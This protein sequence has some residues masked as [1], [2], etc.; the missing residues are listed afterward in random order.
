MQ[1]PFFTF[2]FFALMSCS[3]KSQATVGLIQQNSAEDGYELFAP[4]KADTTYLIDKCG[5]RIHQWASPNFPGMSVYLLPD[6]SLL[7]SANVPNPVF[8]GNGA[9]GGAI[10]KYDWNNNL[11]W[12]YTISTDTQ[13]QNH[14]IYPMPNGNILLVIWEAIDSSVAVAAGKN[15]ALLLSTLFS[16][17]I[18]ELQTVGTNQATIVWQWRL[19]DHLIQDFDSTKSNYGVI[20]DHPELVNLN[21]TDSNIAS[22]DWIHPNAVT[23][24]P[25]LDQVILS[26]HNLSEI[27]I[28]DHS[29]TTAE[30]GAHTGG[31]HNKGGDLLYR[32]GNPQVYNRGTSANEVFYTQH[33][34]TWIPAGYPY[35]GSIIIFNNGLK[36]PGGSASS[37]DIFTPPV[38]SNGNYP[39]TAGQPY[40]PATEAWTYEASPANSFF[41]TVMGSAQMLTDGNIV[42]C[43]ATAG[44]FF[45]L[46]S[47][48]NVLWRYINPVNADTI[49]PQGSVAGNNQ[50]FRC[51]Q[52][53]SSYSAFTGDSLI[54]MGHIEKNA[55]L[56][57]CDSGTIST[58]IPTVNDGANI[59]LYPNPATD[60]ITVV[61][62]QSNNAV[63]RIM[64]LCGR[65]VESG[66]GN[67]NK[68]EISLAAQVNGIYIV[69]IITGD[70][71][72][73][74]K[75]IINR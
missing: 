2:L 62:D 64:D 43:E 69:Q 73:Q 70:Q 25:A 42:V 54:P 63:Y 34:P 74:R 23:Y 17:K 39:I 37:V 24:N 3:V 57:A 33:N 51:T 44:N 4:I 56:T 52:Y 68:F 60:K 40:G 65:E 10:E 16:A 18:E 75:I 58:G 50:V 30:A 26:A 35:A 47:G 59:L 48:K 49:L 12:S 66:Y 55:I 9:Q 45:E 67:N 53:A 20:A 38:D 15:P 7:R 1:K 28:L 29:T 72:I 14:D 36:R 32:W 11:L 21:Y 22:K 27:W 19:W 6:G 71:K 41:S 61:L 46:D 13:T 8:R 5:R 31:V